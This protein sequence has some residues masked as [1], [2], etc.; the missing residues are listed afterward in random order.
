LIELP[1]TEA[2]AE[3][4]LGSFLVVSDL[5]AEETSESSKAA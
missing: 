1:Q 2:A 4:W 3:E 5:E